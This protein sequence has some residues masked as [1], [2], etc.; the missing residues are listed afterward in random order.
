MRKPKNSVKTI[1]KTVSLRQADI[2]LMDQMFLEPEKYSYISYSEII[3]AGIYLAFRDP[4]P[5]YKD[6][7]AAGKLKQEKL[8]QIKHKDSITDE[9]YALDTL[10][11]RILD[12]VNG[13][14]FVIIFLLANYIEARPLEG[15]KDWGLT[16]PGA[17]QDH[18]S[19]MNTL[20]LKSRLSPYMRGKLTKQYGIIF[21]E[22]IQ[23]P[24]QEIT[25]TE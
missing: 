11:T 25:K 20:P 8:K 6:E 24:P 12:D 3:R 17:V 19:E 9:D 7:T 2:D 16:N 22:D 23:E 21:P 18:F 4:K 14:K 1:Q 10:K 13:D 5:F 15:I